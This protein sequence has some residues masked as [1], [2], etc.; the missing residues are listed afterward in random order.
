MTT[1]R[2]RCGARPWALGLAVA[3]AAASA[4]AGP[5]RDE[6]SR[7]LPGLAQDEMDRF[8]RGRAAFRT[9]RLS[10]DRADGRGGLGPV[11]NRTS[12]S[13]C[14]VRNGRG[15]PP[16]DPAGPLTGMVLRLGPGSQYG[17]QL[18]DKALPGV[19]PEGRVAFRSN[20]P[21]RVELDGVEWPLRSARAVVRDWVLGPPDPRL[22]LSPRVAPQI[23]GA[24][25]L[26]RIPDA[27]L[28]ARSDPDD[29]DGDGISGRRGG[30]GTGRFGWRAELPGVE[31][32]VARALHEDLGITSRRHPA[33]NCAAGH[34]A[35]A[36]R[37][38]SGIEIPDAAFQNLVSYVRQLAPPRP[39]TSAAAAAGRRVFT[40]IG[41]TACHVG[42]WKLEGAPVPV[43]R[44]YTDLLL[45][46][47]GPGL[48]D[49]RLDGTLGNRE[50]RTAPLWG[51][52]RTFAVNGHRR[53]L[54]DG[55]AQGFVEAILWH[56]GEAAAAR[57]RFRALEAAERAAVL[58]FLASL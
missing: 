55:R 39:R 31:D 49:R 48:A 40:A 16:A 37:A 43:I 21:I 36:A 24:G 10:G 8:A 57:D 33:A 58:A 27:A 14:H 11:F 44:P 2:F 3:L 25:L 30:Q 45:H 52:G 12:C 28:T 20:P 23:A 38:G 19:E 51:I 34:A 47:L 53:L 35:C 13:G 50:W 22:E 46:D 54:H 17:Q 15:H 5:G 9:I 18:N 4:A 41:C 56:G 29:Q 42:E 26:E 6:F 7:P 1:A 32:Q